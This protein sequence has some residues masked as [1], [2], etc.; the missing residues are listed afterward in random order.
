MNHVLYG[1][2]EMGRATV[3]SLVPTS[4]YWRLDRLT[5][6][7]EIALTAK[8]GCRAILLCVEL[9]GSTAFIFDSVSSE[10]IRTVSFASPQLTRPHSC[11]EQMCALL[12][13]W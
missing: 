11:G 4:E 2:K 12:F 5:Y 9:R 6:A 1:T 13:A 3:L 7:L 8:F 10:M